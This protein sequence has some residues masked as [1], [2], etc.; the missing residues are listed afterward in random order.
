MPP[1]RFPHIV[2]DDRFRSREDYRAHR[3][4]IQGPTIPARPRDAHAN[5]L[6]A[7]LA[8]AWQSADQRQAVSHATRDGIYL[9]FRSDPG[10][11]LVTKSLEEL[12]T[13]K[14]RLLNVRAETDDD[15]RVTTFATVYVSNDK[16]RQFLDKIERYQHED[17]LWGRPKGADL[18]NSIADL[19]D[20]LL[21]ESFWT[22]QP[23][24]IPAGDADFIE[25]WLSGD[26]EEIE[27]EFRRLC[28]RLEIPV[29][30]GSVSFPERRV[31]VVR[32]NREQLGFLSTYSDAIAEYRKA[33]ETAAYWLTM[34]N[35]EQAQWVR[36]L[37]NRVRLPADVS[38]TVCILDTGVNNGHPLLA[39]VLDGADCQAIDPAWGGADH[40]GHGTLMSGV[41]SYGDLRAALLSNEPVLLTHHLESVKILPPGR[42]ENPKG[43]WGHVTSQA[44][45]LAEINAGDRKRII[46]LAVTATDSRDRGRPS[47][48][49]GAV[50]S[51]AF[52]ADG[53]VE[54]LFVISAGNIPN[55]EDCLLY[56]EAQILESIHDPAQSWNALCVGAYTALEHIADPARAAEYSPIAPAGGLS[57]FTSTS[58]TWEDSWPLKPDIVMEGGNLAVDRTGFVDES[59][60]LCVLS[61][62][63]DLPRRLLNGFN[64]TS[65]ATAQAACWCA[66][67]QAAYPYFRPETIRALMVHSAKW[68]DTMR[69]Q[70]LPIG[71][72]P[73]KAEYK[74]LIRICG[75]GVPDIDR[76]LETAR[77]HLTLV[78]EAELQPF[79]IHAGRVVTK[80]MHLHDLPWPAEVLLGL[81]PTTEV[82]MRV[83]LSYFVEPG[84]GEIG[85]KDRYRYPSHQLRFSVNRPGET[86][87]AFHARISAAAEVDDDEADDGTDSQYWMVGPS[88]RHRGSIHSDYWRG[89]AADLATSNLLAVYPK[90]GWW[91]ERVHLGKAQSRCW[92]SLVVSIYTPEQEID[93]YTPVAQQVGIPVPVA[94]L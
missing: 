91:K 88:A 65:A 72:A 68:T 29:E 83:T 89:S 35:V 52:G 2:L 31:V 41:A 57:P 75:W 87:A 92:Y 33:K 69:R 61:T 82:S 30:H 54:R 15:G 1:E 21:V 37:A 63:R 66:R 44:V 8:A 79:T 4:T 47:S 34:E 3:Q 78:A 16:R 20:A 94:V 18:I 59:D 10:A 22:D 7:R 73:F 26:E 60:D 46:C 13:K 70:F 24:L 56:P 51:A 81:S 38:T 50:D 76:A 58:A 9:E 49:S 77:N 25:V 40:H 62:D 43:L 32:A 64:M 12:R 39:G 23:A 55:V 28:E 93:I 45:S 84:P 53:G 42:A 5:F 74:R 48:W 27:V 11:I 80:D 6:K 19:R 14:V 85:W 90:T 17:T 67:I 71:R 86:R 36:D